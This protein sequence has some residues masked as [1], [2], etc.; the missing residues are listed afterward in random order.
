MPTL[1][2]PEFGAVVMTAVALAATD[3]AA[4]SRLLVA[5]LAKRLGVEPG[6]IMAYQSATEDGEEE[7]A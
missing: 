1:T 5:W 3:A 2:W 7:T 6:E 4:L